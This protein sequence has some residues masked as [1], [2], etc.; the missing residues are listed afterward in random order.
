M[1]ASIRRFL[2]SYVPRIEILHAPA[3]T[4]QD[5]VTSEQIVTE[6]Y[7]FLQG[8]FFY[9]GIDPRDCQDL[10]TQDDITELRIDEASKQLNEELHKQWRQGVDLGLQFELRHRDGS[11]EFMAKD[12]SVKGRKTR[13]SKRSAGVT[14][15]FRLSM[16][17]HAR[18]K[19]HPANTHIFLF[20]EPGI[21]LHPKGQRDLIQV[22]EQL[23]DDSQLVYAT[24]SL[25]LLNQNHP[26]RHRLVIRDKTGT[27]V[28]QKP[29]QANWRHATDA[30]GVQLTANILFSPCVLLVEGDSDPLYLYE[31]FR[32]L[33]N[34]GE[35]DADA[36]MLGIYSYGKHTQL[37]VSSSD[38]RHDN[39]D[40][41]YL[42]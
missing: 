27:K 2:R 41:R 3:G 22:L 8:V 32:Q 10:F 24:H 35:I 6:D 26:E 42:F 16:V 28:D 38:V 34:R 18:R 25:F 31:L 19:K 14:Q 15:F 40:L 20:D 11:I 39:H 13:M 9:A 30:L 21:Y 29:Y 7:E 17:L 36:N 33:N 1:P 5:S 4:L 12:P 23:A 37:T